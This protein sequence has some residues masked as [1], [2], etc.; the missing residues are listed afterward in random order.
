MDIREYLKA[1]QAITKTKTVTIGKAKVTIREMSVAESDI[2]SQ[3]SSVSSKD[4]ALYLIK[5]CVVD[6]AGKPVFSDKDD[7]FLLE[8]SD[9]SMLPLVKAIWE[10]NNQKIEVDE[11]GKH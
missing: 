2:H 3:K 7:E 6:D 5:T 9:K 11:Q 4:G 8:T 10:F 1:N